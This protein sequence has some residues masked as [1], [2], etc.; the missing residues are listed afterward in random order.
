M[1]QTI[2]RLYGTAENAEAA[3]KELHELGFGDEE[4]QVVKPREGAS[5]E[6][7]AEMIRKCYVYK[8][9]AK[10]YAEGVQR[11]NTLVVVHAGFGWAM[12]AIVAMERCKPVAS[13]VPDWGEHRL[14]WDEAAPFSSAFHLPLLSEGAAPF[15]S[16]WGLP[17]LSKSGGSKTS[18]LG[19]PL[20]SGGSGEYKSFLGL[21][22]LSSNPA[23]LSS[24]LGLPTLKR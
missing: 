20:L 2:C 9:E 21:P 4:L 15:S 23:P 13:G 10:A 18:M 14:D 17:V 1:T 8:L 6:E 19:L 11:G 16:F 7:L 3:V 5:T 12:P 22:L 24:M